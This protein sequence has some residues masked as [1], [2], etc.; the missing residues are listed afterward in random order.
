MYMMIMLQRK[1]YF[2]E[3]DGYVSIEAEN[4]GNE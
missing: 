1:K 4:F 3:K 2:K